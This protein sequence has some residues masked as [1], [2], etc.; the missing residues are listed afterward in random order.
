MDFFHSLHDHSPGCATVHMKFR[1]A[2]Y[3]RM[4]PI[5]TGRLRRRNRNLVLESRRPRLNQRIDYIVLMADGRNIHTMVVHVHGVDRHVAGIAA[6]RTGF[7]RRWHLH[8]HLHLHRVVI[9]D[10]VDDVQVQFVPRSQPKSRRLDDLIPG[11]VVVAIVS[12]TVAIH[13]MLHRQL[14]G[15]NTVL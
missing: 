9:V 2:V 3:V 7:L 8:F 5:Q 15:K 4:V 10:I 6:V 12:V 11:V 1:K 13:R 14:R